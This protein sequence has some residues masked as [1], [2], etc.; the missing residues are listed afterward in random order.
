MANQRRFAWRFSAAALIS[1]LMASA[2]IHGDD[3]NTV[4]R[5]STEPQLQAAVQSLRS[6]TT[7]LIA[8][9][10]YALTQSLVVNG[11]LSNVTLQ[12]DSAN[13]DD[14]LLTGPGMTHANYGLVPYGIATGGGV[15]NVTIA[16]LMIRDMYTYG[17]AFA[18]GT[19]NPHVDNVHLVDMGTAFIVTNPNGGAPVDGGVVEHSLIE[20]TTTAN[21]S[22]SYGIYLR[23]GEDWVI[24]GNVFRNIVG[25]S[26]QPAGAAISVRGQASNTVTDGNSFV[27]CWL[28]IAYGMDDAA[29][30]DQT[31]GIIRN[32]VFFRAATQAGEAGIA[33]SNSPYTTV[34]NNT[35]FV[36]GTFGTPIVYAFAGSHDLVVAN[37]LLDGTIWGRDGATAQ[38]LTNLPG[39][40]ADLFTDAARGD[41]HLAAA[42]LGAIDRGTTMQAAF[43]DFDGQLR[44]SGLAY[45]I[46]A[47]EVTRVSTKAAKSIFI[48][49]QV[50]NANGKAMTGVTVRIS[51]DR[52]GSM[53]TDG[54]GIYAFNNLPSGG[55]YQVAPAESAGTFNPGSRS[56]SGV[57]KYVTTGDFKLAGSSTPPSAPA[58]SSP[59]P[60]APTAGPAAPPTISL[61]GP[62]S[63]ST[64]T[65]PATI[66]LTATASAGTGSVT[67]VQF[68]TGGTLIGSDSNGPYTATW[69][70]ASAGTYALSAVVTNSGGA[71]ATSAIVTVTVLPAPPAAPPVSQQPSAQ[72][73]VV[74]NV[75]GQTFAAASTMLTGVGLTATANPQT[76]MVGSQTP[77]AGTTVALHSTVTLTMV[78]PTPPPA[79]VPSP[80]PPAVTGPIPAPSKLIQLSDLSAW[81]AGSF[82]L[83][84][85]VFGYARR[86][87]AFN[88]IRK[89]L[90][91]TTID[92]GA[93]AA[94]VSIPPVGGT[95]ALLRGPMDPVEGKINSI[96]GNAPAYLGG[97]WIRADGSMVVSAYDFY[98]GS[99]G[100]TGAFFTRP[101]D[102]STKGQ[103]AGAFPASG[104]PTAKFASGYFGRIPAAW[105][106]AL[107]GDTLVGQ[108]CTNIISTSSFGP[109]VG[110]MR[111]ADIGAGNAWSPLVYYTQSNPLRN[112]WN[113]TSDIF[114]GTTEVTGVCFPDGTDTV[115]FVGRQGTGSYSYGTPGSDAGSDPADSNKGNHAYP[116]RHQVW[117]YDAHDFAAVRAGTKQPWQVQPYAYGLLGGIPVRTDKQETLGCAYDSSS[118]TLYIGEDFG[119]GDQPL[120][121]VF[122]VK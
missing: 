49:G 14:V 16:N 41:L 78:D 4:V 31:G 27:N 26:R 65:A 106:P 15:D 116:Y 11:A 75:V 10:T 91:L 114:N 12:G 121:H 64:F 118:K 32:N 1:L 74:P 97:F 22:G 61:T 37:N 67:K 62:S 108:C 29:V 82:A 101:G 107:G 85:G 93:E 84:S 57:T 79:P 113:V 87:L 89:S 48:G 39:A 40:T 66:T 72:T 111:E 122:N 19:S 100:Q 94:E 36:S 28:G 104:A 70:G 6:N 7:I 2:V 105:Q 47:Y 54:A 46:G 59:T 33:V 42:G 34:V 76:G 92:V 103:V 68:F 50:F 112:A 60:P 3:S 95:A 98:D 51:G 110:A 17:I 109:A 24:Q 117:L 55:S 35:V 71:T 5:V 53:T 13:R 102:L 38:E 119:D 25:P 69:G 81:H 115:M 44:P 18:A 88:P 23:G 52:S 63:G 58:P 20:Y 73:I 45:D 9:G 120:I 77:A 43:V 86:G 80:L 96:G 83:P 90:V 56:Y 21:V 8:P 99:G 30:P